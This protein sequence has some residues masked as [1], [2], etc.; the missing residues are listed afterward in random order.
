MTNTTLY[1]IISM[2]GKGEATAPTVYKTVNPAGCVK[3]RKGNI[4]PTP[5]QA[6]HK[7][8][9]KIKWKNFTNLSHLFPKALDG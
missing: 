3:K 7:E 2:Q 8:K 6:Q 4:R 1:A 5:Y 9:R